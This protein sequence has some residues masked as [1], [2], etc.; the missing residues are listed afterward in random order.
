[1]TQNTGHIEDVY[2]MSDIQKGMVA[3]SLLHPGEGLYHDQFT[4]HI[5]RVD[6][7]HFDKA[8]RLMVRKHA[9]LRTALDVINYSQEVQIVY[10]EAAVD[11]E[12]IDLSASSALEQETAIRDYIGEERKRP[13]DLLAAPLWRTTVFHLDATH[14]VFLFQFHHAILDGWSV[15][16]FNTELFNLYRQLLEEPSFTPVPLKSSNREHVLQEILAKK[17]KKNRDYWQQEM[18]D[19]KRLHIFGN[20]IAEHT[21]QHIIHPAKAEQLRQACREEKITLK[22]VLLGAFVYALNLLTYDSD[23]TIG[24]VS[25]NRPLTEDG[26]KILGCYLNTL[27]WRTQLSKYKQ[28]SWLHYFQTLERKL[29]E[30]NTTRLTLLEISRQLGEDTSFGNPFF[31]VIFNYVDFHVYNNVATTTNGTTGYENNKIRLASHEKTNTTL[32]LTVAARN[33]HLVF[34][35]QYNRSLVADITPAQ[36]HEY[37]E[38]VLDI[39][40]GDTAAP[41]GNSAILGNDAVINQLQSFNQTQVDFPVNTNVVDLFCQQA[42]A[43]P[44]SP[45]IIY[46]DKVITYGMADRLSN[47]LAHYLINEYALTAGDLVGLSLERS[48]W[49]PV[50]VMAI[51][52]TGAAYVPLDTALPKDRLDFIA[53]DGQFKITITDSWLQGLASLVDTMPADRPNRVI[54]PD[55]VIYSIYT[56]GS[57]GMP[58]GVLIAHRSVTNLIAWFTQRYGITA[59]S[60]FIQLTAATFDPFIEDIFGAFSNGAVFHIIS[61]EL[62]YDPEKLRQYIIDNGITILNCVPQVISN[63]LAFSEE[64][65]PSISAVI[66]GGDKLPVSLR[67]TLLALGYNLYNNYGPTE[68]TV[69]ALSEQVSAEGPVTIGKPVA[70]CKAYILDSEQ[71][72]LATGVAG[73]LCIGGAGVAIGYLNNPELT[74]QKFVPDPYAGGRMYR[75][76]DLVRWLPSGTVE[77]LNRMDEQV[78]VRGYRVETG[79]IEYFLMQ[80]ENVKEAVVTTHQTGTGETELAAYYVASTS[81]ESATLIAFLAKYLPPYMIPSWFVQMDQFPLSQNG[82]IDRKALPVPSGAGDGEEELLQLPAGELEVKLAEVWQKVLGREQIG[83][84]QNF[85][86]LG[87][88]SLKVVALQRQIKKDMD[89]LVEIVDLFSHNTIEQ[90]AALLVQKKLVEEP[91]ATEEVSVNTLN[92]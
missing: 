90:F 2:P 19:F 15:A 85:F 7:D 8:L 25:N 65:I 21:F 78:K 67:D 59:D 31:D 5:P 49:L 17:D 10:K 88:N 64:K 61:R 4:Y 16:S 66:S 38:K 30:V 28:K 34:N 74:A 11:T 18:H 41:V 81:I 91:A 6:K 44:D 42:T 29:Q 51:L 82:K 68:I 76:G 63:L 27:P 86:R 58:K 43:H 92:F 13:F 47:Q 87:G 83:V 89:V 37:V 70:N 45:A 46:K 71:D 62:L 55:Q 35:Y 24:L 72:L 75:T 33:N 73:E 54:H 53:A 79:E 77:Y 56:S 26:D 52:K 39:F 60:R 50:T 69:D 20:T 32:D 23:I 84:N 12:I 9:T 36:L 80:A 57:T 48:E 22:T 1:M 14:S 3:L 40:L